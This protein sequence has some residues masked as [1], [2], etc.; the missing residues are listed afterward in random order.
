MTGW[1]VG[2]PAEEVFLCCLKKDL[3]WFFG[4]IILCL[5]VQNGVPD[6][7]LGSGTFVNG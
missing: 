6:E 5:N 3:H 4:D 7:S 2:M 1:A